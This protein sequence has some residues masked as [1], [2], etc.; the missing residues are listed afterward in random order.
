MQMTTDELKQNINEIKDILIRLTK[1]IHGDGT[2]QVM[3]SDREHIHDVIKQWQAD[4]VEPKSRDELI[5]EWLDTHCIRCV[6]NN[7]RG[8]A[9]YCDCQEECEV[10]KDVGIECIHYEE[11]IEPELPNSVDAEEVNMKQIN[12]EISE[13][14]EKFLKMLIDMSEILVEYID[15]S[16]IVDDALDRNDLFHL[17]EKL[18]FYEWS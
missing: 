12:C 4:K 9:G 13:K 14:E 5:N 7:D 18:G 2:L 10:V 6:N 16:A 17:K 3:L 11:Y 1:T 8:S 15:T